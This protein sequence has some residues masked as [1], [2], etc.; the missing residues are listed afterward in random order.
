MPKGVPSI[1]AMALGL[2]KDYTSG[3]GV[4]CQQTYA[5]PD[6]V[7]RAELR[8]LIPQRQGS[9]TVQYNVIRLL[10]QRCT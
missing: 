8:G 5:Q 3:H 6:A 9:S 2:V 10:G 7:C 4:I 1:P